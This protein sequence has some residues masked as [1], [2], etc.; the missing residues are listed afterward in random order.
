VAPISSKAFKGIQRRSKAFKDVQRGIGVFEGLRGA[1][2]A[3]RGLR[4]GSGSEG[5]M[6]GVEWEWRG[7]RGESPD[8]FGNYTKFGVNVSE[9]QKV[10][11]KSSKRSLN[12]NKQR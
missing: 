5:V 11:C 1:S 2:K 9:I 8:R 12:L 10:I 4:G 6:R 3:R 7:T